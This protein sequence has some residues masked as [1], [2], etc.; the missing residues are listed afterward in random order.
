ME[1]SRKIKQRDVARELGIKESY[2]S[3]MLNGKR[4]PSW[5]VAKRCA[6]K[7]HS[8]PLVWM[9]GTKEDIRNLL[10]IAFSDKDQ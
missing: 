1:T 2:L 3:E 6:L 10:V 8:S 7:T 4:R 5:D 9:E